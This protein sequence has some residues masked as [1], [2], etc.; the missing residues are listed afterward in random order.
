[1][2][3]KKKRKEIKNVGDT[4]QKIKADMQ[5]ANDDWRQWAWDEGEV[6]GVIRILG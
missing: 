4:W 3:V 6:T 5:F 2:E 1:V